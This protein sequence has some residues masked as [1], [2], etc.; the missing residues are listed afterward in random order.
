MRKDIKFAV[1]GVG[2]LVGCFLEAVSAVLYFQGSLGQ[3]PSAIAFG[4]TGWFLL[5]TA[6]ALKVPTLK[7]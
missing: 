5:S 4:G 2:L 7:H 6:V 1:I 3:I